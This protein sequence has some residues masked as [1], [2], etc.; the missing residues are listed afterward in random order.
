M[1]KLF[2]S[3]R[4]GVRE[5][6][7]N[8]SMNSRRALG[9]T[10]V[11]LLVVIAII[12]ILVALLLPAVQA[13]REAARR[14]QCS[15]NLKQ[16]GLA[17]HTYHSAKRVFPYGSA[18]HDWEAN[19]NGTEARWGGS[20]R[21]FLLPFM[22]KPAIADRL[23]RI[24][25]RSSIVSDR[26]SPWASS[27]LQTVIVPGYVC[28]SEPQPWVRNGFEYWSFGPQDGAAI[29]TYMGCAG[30]VSTGPLDWGIFGSCGLCTDGSHLDAFCPC[31]L[32]NTPQY[33][34]GF[35]HGH[36]PDGPGMLDMFPN[37][38]SMKDVEDGA[39]NTIH[40]GETHGVNANG[41]GCGDQLNWMSTWAVSS[42]VYGI[43]AQNVGS[44]WQDG[45]NFRSYH[46]G[47]AHFLFVDGSVHFLS[48]TVD[49]WTFGYLGA[50]NDG[51]AV[52]GY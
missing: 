36:N 23:S 13:A 43:N 47:G 26:T 14:M 52:S 44:T 9:F 31:T 24:N 29:S 15:N 2:L 6:K 45:C 41:D 12:G 38:I 8:R 17:M 33:N 19:P 48:E 28:P 11:E 5:S 7:M 34:R 42:T 39:S 16:F 50:R 18:D 46:P 21:T 4:Y 10:L 25:N 27:P 37:R 3:C 51:Q 20:W 49:L 1:V 35:Y 40:V 30:P 22:D 32:G